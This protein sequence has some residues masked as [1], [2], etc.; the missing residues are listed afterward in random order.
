MGKYVYCAVAAYLDGEEMRCK[1]HKDA[2]RCWED[3]RQLMNRA[4]P[5]G[6]RF[7]GIVR[8]A[9]EAADDKG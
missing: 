5:E 7:I 1:T 4:K 3:L 9:K 8:E 6:I 2:K